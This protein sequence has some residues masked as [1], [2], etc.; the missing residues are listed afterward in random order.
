MKENTQ[1]ALF[2]ISAEQSTNISNK[3]WNNNSEI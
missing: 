1:K 2:G 3:N